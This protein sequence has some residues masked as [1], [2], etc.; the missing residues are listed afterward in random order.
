MRRFRVSENSAIMLTP[1]FGTR[2]NPVLG[3]ACTVFS[4]G[5]RPCPSARRPERFFFFPTW[6]QDD[7]SFNVFERLD[8]RLHPPLPGAPAD[9][10]RAHYQCSG[11]SAPRQRVQVGGPTRFPPHLDVDTLRLARAQSRLSRSRAPNLSGRG[12]NL[13]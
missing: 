5:H 13:Y 11:A 1:V 6:E 10:P 3:S 12:K 8:G 4:R 9:P 7:L 2:R